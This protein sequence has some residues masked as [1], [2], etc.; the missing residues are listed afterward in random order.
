MTTL[1]ALLYGNDEQAMNKLTEQAP[2]LL[3]TSRASLRGVDIQPFQIAM[4]IS[5]LLTM[6]VGN[7][8]LVAWEQERS[9][10]AAGE[11]TLQYPGSRQVVRLLEHTVSS[12]QNPT[13]DVDAG[14]VR[15]TLLTLTLQVDLS[16]SATDLV[17]EQGRVAEMRAGPTTAWASLSAG[18]ALLARSKPVEVDLVANHRRRAA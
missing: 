10:R 4:A 5:C 13:I 8:A 11:H 7:L 14:P 9:V 18:S 16:I 1:A 17:I 6:P 15:A 3:A 2:A 12:T